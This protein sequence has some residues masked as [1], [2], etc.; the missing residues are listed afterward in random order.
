[1][2]LVNIKING[3]PYQVESNL[4]VLEAA[5]NAAMKSLHYA[6]SIMVNALKRAAVFA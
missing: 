4:T 2:S 6:L 3:Q 1:M 5:R